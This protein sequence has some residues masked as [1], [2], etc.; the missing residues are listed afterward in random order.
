MH[1]GSN[2][3]SP[4]SAWQLNGT[5]TL[6]GDSKRDV[7]YDVHDSSSR[8]GSQEDGVRRYLPVA[9]VIFLFIIAANASLHSVDVTSY[10]GGALHKL[11]TSVGAASMAST[12]IIARRSSIALSAGV[13][14]TPLSSENCR[15][16]YRRLSV[17]DVRRGSLPY[18]LGGGSS[19]ERVRNSDPNWLRF[20]STMTGGP[21][22]PNV[23]NLVRKMLDADQQELLTATPCELWDKVKGRTTWIYGDSQS[24]DFFKGIVCTLREFVDLREGPPLPPHR[25]EYG[26]FKI[27]HPV[28]DN[29]TISKHMYMNRVST[30]PPSCIHM[31]GGTRVCYIRLDTM[32]QMHTFMDYILPL[33]KKPD[34]K[35]VNFGLHH[36][37][38][39]LVNKL[40]MLLKKLLAND[41]FRPNMYFRDIPPQHFDT[42]Y[43]LYPGRGAKGPFK[44]KARE[45]A[46]LKRDG[47]MR[48]EKVP[49]LQEFPWQVL[50]KADRRNRQV[51]PTI[52]NMGIPVVYTYNQTTVLHEFH[53]DNGKGYECTHYCWPVQ[54]V[55]VHSMLATLQ[56]TPPEVLPQAALA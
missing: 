6:D 56:A 50:A 28:T 52:R 19:R 24:L 26:V 23:K 54:G 32:Q 45:G 1:A 27:A 33:V 43:G 13:Q 9:F 34:I 14:R 10:Y 4:P 39:E 18:Y 47:T 38:G 48:F 53:R 35:I 7:R 29:V 25:D 17:D 42:P 11:V 46:V 41:N 36:N 8:K 3:R 51:L 22:C 5:P 31:A 44:C 55:W 16:H 12:E 15:D 20:C 2:P 49:G 30:V 37:V 21:I 40:P